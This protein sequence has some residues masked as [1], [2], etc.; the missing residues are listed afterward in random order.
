MLPA[1]LSVLAG[2]R[3]LEVKYINSPDSHFTL[4]SNVSRTETTSLISRELNLR[5]PLVAVIP[6]D[7]KPEKTANL[8]ETGWACV[9][10]MFMKA[11]RGA[12]VALDRKT[13]RCP[14]GKTGVGFGNSYARN[15][16]LASS[17]LSTGKPGKFEGEAYKKTPQLARAMLEFIPAINLP[18]KYLLFKPLY[19][20]DTQQ[21]TP[22]LVIFLANPDQL[23]A[24]VVLANYSRTN[25]HSVII[26]M[27]SAC[28]SICL[29]PFNEIK[30]A[31]PRAV[32][33]LTDITVRHYLEPDILSF[34]I[35]YN[36]YLQME[37]DAPGSFL[38]KR[39]WKELKKR[40]C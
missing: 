14:G 32:I 27:G 40:I 10:G 9:I 35:P 6:S 22:A 23:S 18:Y 4:A 16:D 38:M 1:T 11:A 13:V 24:L 25:N 37:A 29:Y 39:P 33:G 5:Y 12:T 7:D 28:S 21:E 26:T 15:L 2:N 36:M 19:Q 30:A 34:T 20:V 31:E 17:F 3:R 8:K